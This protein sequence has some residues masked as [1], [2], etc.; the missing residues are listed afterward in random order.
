MDKNDVMRLLGDFTIQI[1]VFA[2][3]LTNPDN[4]KVLNKKQL[5]FLNTYIL[6]NLKYKE[7]NKII[8]DL[9]PKLLRTSYEVIVNH[10]DKNNLNEETM[11]LARI[12]DELLPI[13]VE[14]GLKNEK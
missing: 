2:V 11:K 5:T 12:L 1:D 14:L 4:Y 3:E 6:W 10:M 13:I 7:S 8:N 9:L